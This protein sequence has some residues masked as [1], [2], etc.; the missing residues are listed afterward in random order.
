MTFKENFIKYIFIHT[1]AMERINFKAKDSEVTDYIKQMESLACWLMVN[2]F[3]LTEDNQELSHEMADEFDYI[4]TKWRED[5][6][7]VHDGLWRNLASKSEIIGEP[8]DETI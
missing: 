8:T 1:Y 4:E 3:D 2:D 5:G 6:I 7:I